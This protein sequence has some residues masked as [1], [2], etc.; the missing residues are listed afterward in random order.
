MRSPQVLFVE[1]RDSFTWNV[2]DSLPVPRGAVR[3]ASAAQAVREP[4]LIRRAD[5]VVVGPGPKDPRRAGLLTILRSAADLKKPFLG[6]CLGHQAL[7]LAF[8]ARLERVEPMHGKR[9]RIRFKTSRLFPG[10]TGTA[11]VMRYHSLAL[12]RVR[13]PLAVVAATADGLA[14]A[15]EHE[16][17]PMAGLQF[18]PDSYATPRGRDMLA[19]FFRAAL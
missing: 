5:L 15:V 18:H 19:A 12:T 1:N 9:S 11:V 7:G 4:G 16:R 10:I 14:M 8:G 3:L 17:L 2:V 13:T 6:I